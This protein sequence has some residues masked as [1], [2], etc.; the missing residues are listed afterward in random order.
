M[1]KEPSHL[2]LTV[3]KS[4]KVALEEIAKREGK[5]LNEVAGPVLEG[6]AKAHG[7]GND[8]YSLQMWSDKPESIAL[9]TIYE[10]P[11]KPKVDKLSDPDRKFMRDQMAKW[12]RALQE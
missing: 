5:S 1:F 10:D 3:E 12:Y 9:P 11:T 8:A 2:S 6:F 4:V 7:E